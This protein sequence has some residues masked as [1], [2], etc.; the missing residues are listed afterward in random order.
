[1]CLAASIK[2]ISS[3]EYPT[4]II[5]SIFFSVSGQFWSLSPIHCLSEMGMREKISH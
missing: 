5:F 1:M 2:G 3:L 4:E